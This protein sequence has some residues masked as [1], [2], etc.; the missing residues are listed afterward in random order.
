MGTGV[1]APEWQEAARDWFAARL[2][3][4][5]YGLFVVEADGEV[6]AAALGAI[7]DAAPS[8]T[9][10]TGGGVLINNVCTFPEHRGSG[11]GSDAF[12]AVMDWAR[13]TGVGRAELMATDTGIRIYERVGFA[14]TRWPAMRAVL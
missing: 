3:H 1:D 11:Y 12:S 8:P 14:A 2:D 4:P 10:P 6:V 9:C 13:G 5:D 7:R